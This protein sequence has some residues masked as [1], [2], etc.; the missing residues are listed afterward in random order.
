MRLGLTGVRMNAPEKRLDTMVARLRERGC[1]ITPQRLEI[2]R[3]LAESAGHPS[4]ETIHRR[5]AVLF[6]SMSLATVYKT[7]AVLK[8]AG[9]VMELEFSDRD[10]RYDGNRPKS[11]PHLVCQVCGAI[12][13]PDLAS[14]DALSRQLAEATGYRI[15]SHRLEFYGIC[16]KCRAARD[17]ETP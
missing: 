16:P 14:L 4:A 12:T 15:L 7:I 6:P 10:N 17:D 13:D 8:T 9:E 1:R 3:V 5:A 2:L 11:H